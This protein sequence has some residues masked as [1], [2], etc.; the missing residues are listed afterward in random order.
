MASYL[1]AG[2][3]VDVIETDP[4]TVKSLEQNTWTSTEPHVSE[5]IREHH[6][7]LRVNNIELAVQENEFFLIIVPTPSTPYGNFFS[8]HVREVIETLLG[9]NGA[10]QEE[11]IIILKSTVSPGTCETLQADLLSK[12]VGWKLVYNPEFIALGSVMDNL[13]EPN[14]LLIGSSELK[15]AERAKKISFAISKTKSTHVLSTAGAEIAKLAV[16]TFVTTKISFANLIGAL[17]D[18]HKI[19][20][21]SAVLKAVGSDPRIGNSY[22]KPGLGFGGP[23]FP[24]DNTALSI[25]LREQGL[26]SSMPESVDHVNSLI[27]AQRLQRLGDTPPMGKVLFVGLAYKFGSDFISPSQASE[28]AVSLFRKGWDIIAWDPFVKTEEFPF[29][30][31]RG[32]PADTGFVAVIMAVFDNAMEQEVLDK[33]SQTEV[34]YL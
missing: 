6:G 28:V 4:I 29:P 13:S 24:R 8:G 32:I 3:L 20:E 30:V 16:N 34:H 11:K 5:L 10:H 26:D 18:A 31:V 22:L 17:A 14:L 27:P 2:F 15:A 21:P 7:K 25:A 33:F 19:E 12:T 23:C 9:A 1:K